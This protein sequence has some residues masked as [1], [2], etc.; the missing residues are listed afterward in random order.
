VGKAIQIANNIKDNIHDL[1]Y[2][3]EGETFQLSASIGIAPK[4]D[5]NTTTDLLHSADVACSFAKSAGRNTVRLFD[6]G[7][8]DSAEKRQDI[9]S[10]HQ[11]N[12]A[13]SN[14]LFILYK[15]E[16]VPIQQHSS[17]KDFEIL[18]RMKNAHGEMVNPASFFPTAE[19]YHLTSKIDCWVVN[20]VY[21]YFIKHKSQLAVIDKIAINLSG[22]SLADNELEKLIIAKL[23]DGQLPPEKIYFEITETEAITNGNRTRL[24]MDNIKALGCKFALDDFGRGH[25]SYENTK[26]FP[27]DKI[28]IDGSFI[29][30]MME[31][32]LDHA[33]VKSIC[34]IAKAS[35]QEV[36]AKYVGD[37]KVMQALTKLGVDYG[38]G[39]YFSTPE[40]LVY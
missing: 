23:T 15:Q 21:E 30:N 25:S 10:V 22:Y 16:I 27:A 4:M 6:I 32:P 14:D 31:N 12:N 11:I 38:Q 39:Y 29:C 37:K 13:I 8:D 34:E 20:A 19:R 26:E 33:K 7:S 36:V 3:W 2:F 24:F 5:G 9:L 18:L 1:S 35:N 17:G 28:K 40:P